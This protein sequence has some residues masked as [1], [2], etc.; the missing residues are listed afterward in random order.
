LERLIDDLLDMARIRA[1]RFELEL[2][3]EVVDDVVNDSLDLQAPL[4]DAILRG[5][6]P[7]GATVRVDEDD[8]KLKIETA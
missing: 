1:G 3:R 6:V 2:Q 4:A 7:D 5:E 8:G